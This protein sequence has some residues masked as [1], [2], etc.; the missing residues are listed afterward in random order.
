MKA[1]R[2]KEGSLT[3]IA[4]ASIAAFS[5][6]AAD[7][8]VKLAAN[9]ISSS[10]GLLIYGC[11]TFLTGL[12]WTLWNYT[13]G[14]PQHARPS[15][16][17]CALGVGVAFSGVTVC[18]YKTFEADAPISVAMPLIRLSGLFLAILLGIVILREPLS[19]RYVIG[20]ILACIGLYLVV[21]K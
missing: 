5:M 18:L 9:R 11:C 19:L 13:H 4:Y 14:V 7:A 15:G 1:T 10:L 21:T 8:F 3:W 16:F 12:G 6:A 17:L 20:M 2:Y